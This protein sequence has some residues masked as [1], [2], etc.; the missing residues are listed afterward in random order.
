METQGWHRRLEF[1]GNV[2]IVMHNA[3]VIV[4]FPA[5]A[6]PD[7]W[8]N[9]QVNIVARSIMSIL[10]TLHLSQSSGFMK[11]YCISE[12]QVLLVRMYVFLSCLYLTYCGVD[13]LVVHYDHHILIF[14]WPFAALFK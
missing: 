6:M 12:L 10:D 3:S 9:V 7:E 1:P 2:I 4:Q 5:S 11:M 14:C 13:V 8:G